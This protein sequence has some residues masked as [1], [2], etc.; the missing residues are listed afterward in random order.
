MKNPDMLGVGFTDDGVIPI[1]RQAK[2][3][4]IKSRLVGLGAGM[5]EKAAYAA[6]PDAPIDG[7]VW[8][9]YFPPL[10]DPAVVEFCKRYQ[11]A[12]NKQ[13]KGDVGFSILQYE[14][15]RNV[16]WA[17]QK[18]GDPNDTIGIAKALKGHRFDDGIVARE[19]GADGLVS[20]NYWVAE[21]KDKAISWHYV[22]LK[23]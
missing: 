15:L 6:G 3:M 1:L 9:A 7:Y 12:Y 8:I 22:P 5:S 17:M 19:Y 18:V 11:K 14:T 13:C 10:A 4:G 20:S 21:V 16:L 2:E 23:K